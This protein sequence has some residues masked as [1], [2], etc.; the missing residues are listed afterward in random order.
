MSAITSMLPRIFP[1]SSFSLQMNQGEI[2]FEAVQNIQMWPNKREKRMWSSGICHSS[3]NLAGYE[4]ISISCLYL[5]GSLTLKYHGWPRCGIQKHKSCK[6]LWAAWNILEPKML[7]ELSKHRDGSCLWLW[8][9]AHKILHSILLMCLSHLIQQPHIMVFV[10]NPCGWN[11][12]IAAIP[13]KLFF[14]PPM[15]CSGRKNLWVRPWKLAE[16]PF[17]FFP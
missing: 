9:I 3:F 10:I 5:D 13:T 1:F 2:I 16:C 4:S 15:C 14:S 7:Q 6:H 11:S 8:V 12:V 17:L